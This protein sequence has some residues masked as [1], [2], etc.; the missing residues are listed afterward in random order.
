MAIA[1]W[2]ARCSFVDFEDWVVSGQ[3]A[4]SDGFREEL[5]DIVVGT[6]CFEN[7]DSLEGR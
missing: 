3:W 4:E 2:A 6:V 5:V 7:L 1:C